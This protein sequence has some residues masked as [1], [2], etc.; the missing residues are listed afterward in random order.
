MYMALN[1][2]REFFI[3]L[4]QNGYLIDYDTFYLTNVLKYLLCVIIMNLGLTR[5]KN[6]NEIPFKKY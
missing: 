3:Q 2:N 4:I 1:Q 5:D 6:L